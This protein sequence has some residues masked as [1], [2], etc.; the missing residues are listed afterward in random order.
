[1]TQLPADATSGLHRATEVMVDG[2]CKSGV[3]IVPLDARV[4]LP[5]PRS[6][7]GSCHLSSVHLLSKSN[8]NTKILSNGSP[9]IS[10][11]I[12]KHVIFID[13]S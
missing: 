1:M 4:P 10:A 5:T 8:G 6:I 12:T 13:I 11:K 3:T 2:P 9:K 7:F